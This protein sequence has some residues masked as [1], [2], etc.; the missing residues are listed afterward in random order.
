MT[1]KLADQPERWPVHESRDVWRGPAPFAVRNDL[2]SAPGRAERFW[3]L[4]MEHPGAVVVLA[5]DDE[6][7][8]LVLRQYRHP[9]GTRFVELPAGL[10]DEPG[11]D[12]QVAAERELLEEGAVRADEWDHLNTL[13]TSPGINSERIEVYLARSL[14]AVPDRGGFEPQ[15]EEADMT[16]EWV[17]VDE[18]VDGVLERRLTDGPLATAVLTYEI[19]RNRARS[20]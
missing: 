9:T 4:V 17:P 7:R 3:R 10:L 5:V 18:L 14:T 19:L 12:P 15:H 1:G 13:H 20:A 11:E 16:A 6:E 2:I 8:A